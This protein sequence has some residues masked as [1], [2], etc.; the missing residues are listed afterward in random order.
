MGEGLCYD[1]SLRL[2]HYIQRK[3][4]TLNYVCEARTGDRRATVILDIYKKLINKSQKSNCL[5]LLLD[6]LLNWLSIIKRGGILRINNHGSFDAA[7]LNF[8]K[9]FTYEALRFLGCYRNIS[10]KIYRVL[11]SYSR[12]RYEI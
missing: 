6:I 3:K 9:R 8:L 7:K 2:E 11:G 5:L 10:N 1:E 4:L 12:D